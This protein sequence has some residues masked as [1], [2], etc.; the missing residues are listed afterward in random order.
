MMNTRATRDFEDEITSDT[1]KQQQT[2]SALD[3]LIECQLREISNQ[4]N[5]QIQHTERFN[6]IVS[7]YEERIGSIEGKQEQIIATV[8]NLTDSISALTK[9]FEA[10][11]NKSKVWD[12]T[13]ENKFQAAQAELTTRVF[14]FAVK[15]VKSFDART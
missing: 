6:E 12:R 1:G 15:E 2:G 4:N 13:C 11:K 9:G 5:L 14:E 10:I 7:Q 8:Q 3:E